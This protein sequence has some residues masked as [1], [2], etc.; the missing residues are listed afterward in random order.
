MAIPI[1][2]ALGAIAGGM[3]MLSSAQRMITYQINALMPNQ[4]LTAH[5]LLEL[6]L[7]GHIKEDELLAR[8]KYLGF[9]SKRTGEL[10]ALL[11][12]LM[13]AEELIVAKWRKVFSE[14]DKENEKIFYHE[15][16][17]I[18][19]DSET[20]KRL[21]RIRLFY[22][23]PS[24]FIMFAVR[25]V[26][27][28]DVVK[29]FGYDEEFPEAIIPHVEKAGMKPE[30]LRWYWRAHWDLPSPTQGYEMLHR[31]NPDVLKVLGEKYRDMGLEPDKI[32]TTLNTLKTLLK[33]ADIPRYWRDRLI[34]I[35]YAPITR[36]DLRRIYAMGLINDE[37]LVARLMEL[38]Y[39]KQ[40][41]TLLLQF[42]KEY[43]METEKELTKT[44]IKKAFMYHLIDESETIEFLKVLGY[45]ENEAKLIIQIWQNEI[46][47]KELDDRIDTIKEMFA[48]GLISYSEAITQ[49]DGMNLPSKLRDRILA[50]M[51]RIRLR[52]MRLPSKSDLTRWLQ[53]GLIDEETFRSLMK[54]NNYKEEFIDYYLKEIKEGGE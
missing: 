42:Y 11:R 10:I 1:F 8:M 6:Y 40:D 7:R 48:A 20:A 15:M 52:R 46:K 25:E 35:A 2:A 47:A 51:E 3:F 37:E 41:A 54:A 36:V 44:E 17:K 22:P 43:K 38:G 49:L 39:T 45:D 34:A 9:D 24:D 18:G 13:T 23:S 33:I 53:K 31:L 12:K 26:F 5:E 14:D 32:E 27:N 28:E 29:E 50:E 4:E 30:I 16:Q 21:E 19:I